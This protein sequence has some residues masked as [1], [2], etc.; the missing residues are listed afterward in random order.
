MRLFFIVS[1]SASCCAIVLRTLSISFA[2]SAKLLPPS[3]PAAVILKARCEDTK[4]DAL[5]DRTLIETAS[6]GVGSPQVPHSL[7][8]APRPLQRS[9]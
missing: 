3:I 4:I 9:S 6:H 8:A 1:N 5:S 7:H 2:L